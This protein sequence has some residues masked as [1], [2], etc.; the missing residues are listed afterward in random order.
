MVKGYGETEVTVDTITTWLEDFEEDMQVYKNGVDVTQIQL[1]SVERDIHLLESSLENSHGQLEGL[2]DW[3]DGF[4]G[5]LRTYNNQ[6]TTSHRALFQEMHQ[7]KQEA[8]SNHESLL[9]KFARTGDIINKKFVQ[10][11]TKLEKVVDLV[12]EKIKKEVGEIANDFED[13]GGL[14]G[15]F[16]GEGSQFGGKAGGGLGSH[17]QP[18]PSCCKSPR[19][20][21]G[22]GGCRYGGCVGGGG[23]YCSIDVVIR[24]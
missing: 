5:S 24:V 4:V 8:C 9:G 17:F 1:S 16:R 19:S 15:F 7:H 6:F 18:D 10:L 13:R 20:G 14:E 21:R 11:D 23:S 2:G 22:V 12:G 3:V